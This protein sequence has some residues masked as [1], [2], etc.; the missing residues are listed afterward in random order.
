MI[1]VKNTRE[2]I[3]WKELLLQWPEMILGKGCRMCSWQQQKFFRRL[4]LLRLR[5]WNLDHLQQ[6]EHVSAYRSPVTFEAQEMKAFRKCLA[7][8]SHIQATKI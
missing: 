1:S 3:R 6:P 8:L 2:V 4:C 7:L 5:C